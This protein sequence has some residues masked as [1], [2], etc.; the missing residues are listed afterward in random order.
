MCYVP[1]GLD[2][3][4]KQN[5]KLIKKKKKRANKK[6]LEVQLKKKIYKNR[7]L[8]LSFASTHTKQGEFHC[9]AS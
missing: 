1:A 5:M 8:P 9:D 4:I 7:L 2:R 6:N 3:L